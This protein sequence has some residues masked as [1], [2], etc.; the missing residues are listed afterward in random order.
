MSAVFISVLLIGILLLCGYQI[1]VKRHYDEQINYLSRQIDTL[2]TTKSLFQDTLFQ[3]RGYLFYNMDIFLG[4]I[5]QNE[6]LIDNQLNKMSAETD[7][8]WERNLH[9][10]IQ[11]FKG[12]Y[13]NHFFPKMI[14]YKK[15]NNETAIQ[16]LAQDQGGIEKVQTFLV[17]LESE[18]E[19]LH[20]KQKNMMAEKETKTAYSQM[21][22]FLFFIIMI[23]IF[24]VLLRLFIRQFVIPLEHLASTASQISLGAYIR[25]FDYTERK[26]EVGTLSRSF[27]RMVRMLR[28][29]EKS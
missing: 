16:Q 17:H 27:E 24:L 1:Q 28:N 26:D 22:F 4:K 23:T 9:E 7:P 6:K 13:F 15:Q 14:Q 29:S 5:D 19:Q 25:S 21:V 3:G 2:D 10:D 12:W 8:A 11:E 20:V 18:T